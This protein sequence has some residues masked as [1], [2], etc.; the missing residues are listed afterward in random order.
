MRR[1]SWKVVLLGVMLGIG[2]IILVL[3]TV[4]QACAVC[5]DG[6][7]RGFFWGVLFLMATPFIIGSSIGGWLLYLYRRPRPGLAGSASPPSL[8]RRLCFPVTTQTA[9]AG[10]NDAVQTHQ[11]SSVVATTDR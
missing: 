11:M 9:T 4:A 3:P 10:G 2:G 7:D 8:A 5:V 1:Q 6:E